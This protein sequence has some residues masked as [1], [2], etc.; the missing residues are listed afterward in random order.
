MTQLHRLRA[1]LHAIGRCAFVGA[2][3]GMLATQAVAASPA[4]ARPQ[5][6]PMPETSTIP[7][8]SLTLAVNPVTTANLPLSAQ[9]A[10]LQDNAIANPNALPDAPAVAPAPATSESASLNMPA[11]IKAMMAD[12]SQAANNVQPASTEPK[13]QIHP[14]WLALAAVG[15]LGTAL[16]ARGLTKNNVAVGHDI[17][18]LLVPGIAM[19]GGGLYL[20]FR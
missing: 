12:A 13:H 7:S 8:D 2:L 5:A 9:Y 16:G 11:G 20:T 19:L 4:A 18:I 3:A 17:G 1:Q 15:A 6:S 10:V 14:G